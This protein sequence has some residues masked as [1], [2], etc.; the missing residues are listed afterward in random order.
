MERPA[1]ADA[2]NQDD[3]ELLISTKNRQYTEWI[4]K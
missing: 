4:E 1:P 2:E 3:R